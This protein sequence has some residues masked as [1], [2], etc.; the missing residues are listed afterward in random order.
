M[1]VSFARVGLEPGEKALEMDK[2]HLGEGLFGR[3]ATR[4]K[5]MRDAVDVSKVV[6]GDCPKRSCVSCPQTSSIGAHWLFT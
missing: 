2:T 1:V 6:N 4:L 5:K 3:H